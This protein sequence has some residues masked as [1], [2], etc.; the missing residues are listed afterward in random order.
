ME[1]NVWLN[2]LTPDPDNWPNGDA[3][4]GA[5]L[6]LPQLTEA[7]HISRKTSDFKNPYQRDFLPHRVIDGH[8]LPGLMIS[9]LKGRLSKLTAEAISFDVTSAVH[10]TKRWF[11][12]KVIEK[13]GDVTSL[14]QIISNLAEDIRNEIEKDDLIKVSSRAEVTVT[15]RACRTDIHLS[16]VKGTARRPPIVVW[17]NKTPPVMLAYGPD[18]L[19]MMD[20]DDPCGLEGSIEESAESIVGKV[21]SFLIMIRRSWIAG[22]L[23][24]HVSW[25]HYTQS[26]R[27][28]RWVENMGHS[29]C[30]CLS[31]SRE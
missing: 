7:S 8:D 12:S 27:S 21:S 2:F 28:L 30:T 26:C 6:P 18:I 23:R 4:V 20:K 10:T 24:S 9:R 11:R 1:R 17:E 16:A 22:L 19:K 3:L 15:D 31:Y 13:E 14:S 29:L 5:V 25:K